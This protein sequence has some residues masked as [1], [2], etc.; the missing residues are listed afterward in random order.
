MPTLNANNNNTNAVINYE[1]SRLQASC[2]PLR[3]TPPSSS[4]PSI[5]KC[6]LSLLVISQ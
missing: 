5:N 6:A 1:A 4:P 2:M 3:A